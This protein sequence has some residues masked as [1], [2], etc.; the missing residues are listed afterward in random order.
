M[1]S[2]PLVLMSAYFP[3]FASTSNVISVVANE[4]PMETPVDTVT[5]QTPVSA[6]VCEI[7]F[8]VISP[9]AMIVTESPIYAYTSASISIQPTL[10]AKP[11]TIPAETTQASASTS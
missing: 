11:F 6:S 9:V 5:P 4:P 3:I 2:P 1:I 10:T 7:D 8:T